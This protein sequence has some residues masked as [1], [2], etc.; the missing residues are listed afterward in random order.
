MTQPIHRLRGQV[1]GLVGYG[2]IP[3]SLAEKV[4]PLGLKVVA[5]DPYYPAAEAKKKG[6]N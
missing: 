2:K 6:Y 1:L 5:F 4:Q 3:Q